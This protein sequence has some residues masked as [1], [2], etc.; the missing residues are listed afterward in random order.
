MIAKPF[1]LKVKGLRIPFVAAWSGE[2]PHIQWDDSTGMDAVYTG[3]V[4]H[5]VAAECGTLGKV[6]L[7]EMAPQRQRFVMIHG[8]CQVCGEKITHRVQ[9]GDLD[10]HGPT[11]L[12]AFDEPPACPI[13]ALVAISQCPFAGEAWANRGGLII[14]NFELYT[15]VATMEKGDDRGAL[16]KTSDAQLPRAT[17]RRWLGK[18]LAVHVRMVPLTGMR[19]EGSA[20]LAILE[21][22]AEDELLQRHPC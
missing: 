10:A 20:G 18:K 4:D 5:R 9:L 12:V 13:C 14:E 17:F 21:G 8:L 6:L 22:L 16:F 2:Q 19:I 3:V 7:G 11:K 1:H 15:Q